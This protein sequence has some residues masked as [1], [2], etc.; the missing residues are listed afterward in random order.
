MRD[1]PK[2]GFHGEHCKSTKKVKDYVGIPVSLT[3]VVMLFIITPI[4][5]Y[6]QYRLE[7]ELANQIWKIPLN[8]LEFYDWKSSTLSLQSTYASINQGGSVLSIL[9]LAIQNGPNIG[10]YKIKIYV[11]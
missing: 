10:N 3:V 2:C 5:I 11:T 9:K 6:R 8:Q 1:E 4:V 7:K